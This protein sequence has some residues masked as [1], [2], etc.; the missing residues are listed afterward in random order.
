MVGE[1]EAKYLVNSVLNSV[2]FYMMY[3]IALYSYYYLSSFYTYTLVKPELK[4]AFCINHVH[5]ASTKTVGG[6]VGMLTNA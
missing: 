2:S 4:R 5:T 1:R 3:F 6:R